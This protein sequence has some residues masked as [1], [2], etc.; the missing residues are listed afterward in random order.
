MTAGQPD[1][2]GRLAYIMTM[3]LKNYLE[4]RVK[5]YDLTAEQFYVLKCLDKENGVTQHRLC[6]IVM[7]SAANMTRILDRL[8]KKECIE[9]RPNPEDRRSSLVYLTSAGKELLALVRGELNGLEAEITV[10]LSE[11]QVRDL[12]EGLKT[13][14]ANIVDLT[15]RYEK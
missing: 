9:R 12:R 11:L 13:I 10:G 1:P 7:K 14:H 2:L 4:T 8:E 15:R 5:P 3:A 6:E